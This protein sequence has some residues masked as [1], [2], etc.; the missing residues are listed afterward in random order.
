MSEHTGRLTAIRAKM[1]EHNLNAYFLLNNDAHNSEYLAEPDMRMPWLSNFKGS[2]G[3]MLVTM[4]KAMLWTD[5]RYWLAAEKQLP[6][7][8]TMMKMSRGVPT[9]YQWVE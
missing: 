7:E 4:D 8:W 5:G 6:T 3:Q 9:W 1:Q 2:N